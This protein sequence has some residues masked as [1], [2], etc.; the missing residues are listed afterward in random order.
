MTCPN[1]WKFPSQAPASRGVLSEGSSADELLISTAAIFNRCL[2]AVHILFVYTFKLAQI[3]T[4]YCP[5]RTRVVEPYCGFY[6]NF[7]KCKTHN[8]GNT[9]IATISFVKPRSRY[10]TYVKRERPTKDN[11]LISKNDMMFRN[12]A[13][14]IRMVFVD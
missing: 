11:V 1:V 9:T 14:E 12:Y 6:F 2:H 10:A 8:P 5:S 13:I 7:T 4:D 3:H